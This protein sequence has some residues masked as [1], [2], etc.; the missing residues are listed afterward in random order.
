MSTLT[1]SQVRDEPP[2]NP[3]CGCTT[4]C[5]HSGRCN[6]SRWGAACSSACSCSASSTSKNPFKDLSQISGADHANLPASTCFAKYVKKHK[7]AVSV[8]ELRSLLIVTLGAPFG[9]DVFNS[10]LGFDELILEW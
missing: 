5:A 7:G 2:T 8:E 4:N 3:A 6:C 1:A 10:E 9:D